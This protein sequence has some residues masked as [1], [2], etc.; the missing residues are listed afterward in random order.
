VQEGAFFLGFM[1]TVLRDPFSDEELLCR[2]FLF[3]SFPLR[4]AGT[5]PGGHVAAGRS[6]DPFLGFLLTI[7]ADV[8]ADKPTSLLPSFLVFLGPEGLFSGGS[9]G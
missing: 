6:C 5:G 3:T 1:L 2:S 8:S 7:D 9:P 4:E